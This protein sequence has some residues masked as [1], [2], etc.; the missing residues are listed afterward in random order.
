ML[1]TS[2]IYFKPIPSEIIDKLLDEGEVIHCAGGL[3]IEHPL[4]QP[5]II[6]M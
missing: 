2:K 1:D 4:I 3:M 6:G 5:Y